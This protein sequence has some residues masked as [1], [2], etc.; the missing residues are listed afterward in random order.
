MLNH[1]EYLI[2]IGASL[3]LG[4]LIGFERDQQEKPMGLRDVM[5]VTLGATL[6]TI[7]AFEMPKVIP[8]SVQYDIGRIMAYTVASIGFL[9]SGMIIQSKNKFE[10][11]TTASLLFSLLAVGFFCGM[12]LYPLAI[13]SA[14]AIYLV[15]KLKHIKVELEKGVKKCRRK[16]R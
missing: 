16:R 9:G 12:G 4:G 2:K 8:N 11:I 1:V 6:L 5:L 14:L 3:L 15:L 10:G 13:I 7:I